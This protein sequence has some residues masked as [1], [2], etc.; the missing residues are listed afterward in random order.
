MVK[1]NYLE[2]EIRGFP[3]GSR[4][5]EPMTFLMLFGGSTKELA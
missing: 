2:K 1:A 4:A 3:D 5:H